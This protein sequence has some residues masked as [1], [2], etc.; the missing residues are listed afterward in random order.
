M[1]NFKK[2]QNFGINITGNFSNLSSSGTFRLPN[3]SNTTMNSNPP[4][5]SI[6]IAN[7]KGGFSSNPNIYIRDKEF[8]EVDNISISNSGSGYSVTNS[9]TTTSLTGSG[10]GLIINIVSVN[11]GAISTIQ[12]VNRGIGYS[13]G[14]IVTVDGG[15]NNAQLTIG[16]MDLPNNRL[17]I[18]S[19]NTQSIQGAPV[20]GL[21]LIPPLEIPSSS[22]IARDGTIAY[23]SRFATN[24]GY[25][26]NDTITLNNPN[27]GA[28][29]I[30]AVNGIPGIN[31]QVGNTNTLLQSGGTLYTVGSTLIQISTSGTGKLFACIVNSVNNGTI[32]TYT[33]TTQHIKDFQGYTSGTGWQSFTSQGGVSTA[34]GVNTQLQFNNNGNL[35]ADPSL[36]FDT[37]LTPHTLTSG[38][39]GG[40]LTKNIFN[41]QE[42]TIEDTTLGT[43]KLHIESN[44]FSTNPAIELSY[45]A[46]GNQNA[47][48]IKL[49]SSNFSGITL[50]TTGGTIKQ[51][52]TTGN[53]FLTSDSGSMKIERGNGTL[54]ESKLEIESNGDVNVSTT[55]DNN[56]IRIN[57]TG[58]GSEIILQTTSSNIEL[59][60]SDDIECMSDTINISNNLGNGSTINMKGPFNND[61][62]I[63]T[64]SDGTLQLGSAG[65]TGDLQI[66]NLP[67]GISDTVAQLNVGVNNSGQL[68][69][70]EGTNSPAVQSIFLS[71]DTASGNFGGT[72]TSGELKLIENNNTNISIEATNSIT[73]L[74]GKTGLSNTIDKVLLMGEPVAI[75]GFA[76][77]TQLNSGISATLYGGLTIL[78]NKDYNGTPGAPMFDS[79]IIMGQYGW[80]TTFGLSPTNTYLSNK[81]NQAVVGYG[82]SG[83]IYCNQ[84]RQ[85]IYSNGS[86]TPIIMANLSGGFTG[87][88]PLKQYYNGG[89]IRYL[90][91]ATN[92][93]PNS[94]KEIILPPINEAM[95]GMVIT[96][97]RLRQNPIWYP[98]NNAQGIPRSEIP[99]YFYPTTPDLISSPESIFVQSS[100]VST[101]GIALDPYARL[102][103][104]SGYTTPVPY[105]GIG[106]ATV[107]ASAYGDGQLQQGTP[108]RYFWHY[109]DAYP[110][111]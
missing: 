110:A 7:S 78:P 65:S 52:T 56:E 55:G 87:N 44:Q 9:V 43:A 15:N 85:N 6:Q 12:I 47:E 75:H 54:A 74:K 111:K 42:F 97:V 66:K 71:G 29:A 61:N 95:L 92:Q 16:A 48:A 58:L 30:I 84:I 64:G 22:F 8:G 82:G 79:N 76:G 19:T 31:G 109:I 90:T 107:I 36:T 27:G 38:I 3:I 108:D 60:S 25:N 49:S 96:I 77:S 88:S 41:S 24:Y 94:A 69:L 34:A 50:E 80:D 33:V 14:D 51:N 59:N 91:V 99:I 89:N 37:T 57:S 68:K 46:I 93:E 23:F 81:N 67:L 72:N 62:I 102:V 101:G 104:A 26:Q 53:V 13:I 40:A 98:G 17:V 86:A 5:G 39:S 105:T 100:S 2:P 11:V 35:G 73:R 20:S 45:N 18:D 1:A 83:N 70:F 63:L 103:T 28:S 10:Y 4:I 106:T 21:V 32:L